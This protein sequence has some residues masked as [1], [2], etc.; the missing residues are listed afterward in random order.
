MPDHRPITSVELFYSMRDEDFIE[1]IE[2]GHLDIFCNQLTLD[3]QEFKNY[4]I[5]N[6]A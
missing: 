3:L 1:V 5:R 2:S 4:P 6:Q